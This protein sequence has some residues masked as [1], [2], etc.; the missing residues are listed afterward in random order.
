MV[1]L[2]CKLSFDFEVGGVRRGLLRARAGAKVSR[3][4]GNAGGLLLR[5]V[6][7]SI[8]IASNSL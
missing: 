8:T 7:V 2:V 6:G 3:G 1:L 4:L 5:S